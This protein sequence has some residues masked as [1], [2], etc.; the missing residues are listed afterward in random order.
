V[1]HE[2]KT[3]D[4][5]LCGDAKYVLD[6]RRKAIVLD[7]SGARLRG[8]PSLPKRD[9][10]VTRTRE[11]P[12][13]RLPR[14][15]LLRETVK[16]KHRLTA[17]RPRVENF[18]GQLLDPHVA[19]FAGVVDVIAGRIA[20]EILSA[21]LRAATEGSPDLLHVLVISI[22]QKP[23]LRKQA[24]G[25]L[26][27]DGAIHECPGPRGKYGRLQVTGKLRASFDLGVAEAVLDAHSLARESRVRSGLAIARTFLLARLLGARLER[28]ALGHRAHLVL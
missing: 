18:E 21:G 4:V 2:V 20:R 7:S 26:L 11:V 19:W 13:Q 24:F 17:P 1:P 14:D 6:E 9:R 25:R 8:I 5:K 23:E 27:L 3:I 10:P 22:R 12:H 28:G 16:K 15:G